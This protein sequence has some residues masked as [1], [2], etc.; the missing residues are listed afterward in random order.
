MQQQLSALEFTG[1]VAENTLGPLVI[2]KV[3]RTVPLGNSRSPD[4]SLFD[5]RPQRGH[6]YKEIKNQRS[7]L[8]KVMQVSNRE[9]ES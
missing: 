9:A 7:D 3:I 8:F 6:G 2:P 4:A 5:G 1:S